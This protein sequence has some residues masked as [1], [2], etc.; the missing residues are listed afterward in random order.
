MGPRRSISVL[1]LDRRFG[2][3]KRRPIEQGQAHIDRGGVQCV[4]HRVDVDIQDIVGI[5]R[6]RLSNQHL[7]KIG[8]DAP[9][10]SLVG[11][12]ERRALHR[13]AKSHVVELRALHQQTHLDIAQAFP[14]SQLRKGQGAKLF[15]ARERAHPSIA[16]VSFDAALE[17]RPWQ[18]IHRLGQQSLAGV[19]VKSI[20]C[21]RIHRPQPDT[22]VKA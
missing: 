1:P 2:R 5:Q 6:A 12:H 19:Q 22:S 8:K 21:N 13:L 3:T 16:L 18:K 4:D 14:V 7:R 9:V 11:I 20:C 15:R 10:V 17:C